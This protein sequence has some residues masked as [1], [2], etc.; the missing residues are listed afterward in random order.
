MTTFQLSILYVS[1]RGE[2]MV[3]NWQRYKDSEECGRNLR[4]VAIPEFA[5]RNR[6][7]TYQ[8][9]DCRQR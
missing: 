9:W 1:E 5:W 6:G 3:M 7:N 8:T 2:E 4:E